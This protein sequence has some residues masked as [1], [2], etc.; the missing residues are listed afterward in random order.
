MPGSG[1]GLWSPGNGESP[2]V[3]GER[4]PIG[5]IVSSLAEGRGQLEVPV[6]SERGCWGY[7]AGKEAG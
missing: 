2:K 4:V 5:Y 6:P 7:Q 3:S 1:N